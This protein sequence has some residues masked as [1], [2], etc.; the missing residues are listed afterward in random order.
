MAVSSS[1][2]SDEEDDGYSEEMD[3]SEDVS[4]QDEEE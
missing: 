2:I 1:S 3:L 4:E